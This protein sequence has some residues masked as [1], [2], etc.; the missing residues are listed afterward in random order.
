MG[1][2]RNTLG[3]VWVGEEM[4]R[5]PGEVVR[6]AALCKRAFSLENPNSSM[7]V[8]VGD[9]RLEEIQ[10]AKEDVTELGDEMVGGGTGMGWRETSVTGSHGSEVTIS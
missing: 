8:S 9:D 6:V 10:E 3:K 5:L 1:G 4:I 2:L 7:R